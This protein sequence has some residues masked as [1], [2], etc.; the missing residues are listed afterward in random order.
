MA[1]R[2]WQDDA[3]FA[4]SL[5]R[6]RMNA[7]HG[8]LRIRAELR[9]HGIG[10]EGIE[11]AIAACEVDWNIQAADLLRRRFG[12]GGELSREGTKTFGD[13]FWETWA[14][15]KYALPEDTRREYDCELD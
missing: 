13:L 10:E 14:K 12:A 7:G 4:A 6:G 3:R 9:T 15:M 11:A 5:A 2:G 8:P 1:E